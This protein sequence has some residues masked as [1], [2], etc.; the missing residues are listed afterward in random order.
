MP[1]AYISVGSNLD[2]ENNIL[3][4]MHFLSQDVSV[5]NLSLFYRTEPLNRPGQPDFYNGVVSIETEILPGDLKYQVLR[6]IENKLGR[7]R[8]TDKYASRG[9]DLDILLYDQQV[10]HNEILDIPDPDILK[11]PFLVL[12]LYELNPE[13]ILPEWNRPIREIAEELSNIKMIPLTVFTDKLR[14]NLK[15]GHRK[16]GEFNPKTAD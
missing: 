4:A 3:Q 10:I 7:V 15:D 5:I 14:R 16:G 6:R 2:R 12:P 13:L 8:S 1:R 9:I 11:R